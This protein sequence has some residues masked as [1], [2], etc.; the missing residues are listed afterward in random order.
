MATA[1]VTGMVVAV[2]TGMV[3]AVVTGMVVAVV[4]GMVVAVVTGMVP[5]LAV[6]TW[7][8]A[9]TMSPRGCRLTMR[10]RCAKVKRQNSSCD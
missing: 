6:A 10:W 4:T 8:A 7:M 5:T 2:V 3:V 9:G 1:V